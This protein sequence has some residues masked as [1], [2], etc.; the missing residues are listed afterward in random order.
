MVLLGGA[1]HPAWAQAVAP[2]SA[3]DVA[4]YDLPAAS[5]AQT[6]AAITR[7]SGLSIIV[8]QGVSTDTRVPAV[9]GRL[10]GR[11]AL[12]QA[13]TGTGLSIDQQG[14][15]LRVSL[16]QAVSIV[17]KRDKAE[18]SFKADRSDT[19]TR[20][21]TYLMDVPMAVTIVTSKVLESQQ[22][23]STLEALRNVSG[24]GLALT[25][26][27]R[28]EFSVRGF[29]ET[30]QTTNGI[31]D[32]SAAQADVGTVERIEVLK[33]PQ[34]ILAGGDSLGGGVNVVTKRPTVDTVRELTLQFGSGADR[35]VSG[36]V[37]G[38]LSEDKRWSYRLIGSSVRSGETEAGFA[39][40]HNDSLMPSL[41]F[42]D[43]STDLTFSASFSEGR[44]P[45]PDYTFASASGKILSP[46]D[47]LLGTRQDGVDNRQLR[48]GYELEQS[49]SSGWTMVSRMH[50][51][52]DRL[53]LHLWSPF[54]QM[55]DEAGALYGLF[56]ATNDTT[57]SRQL[58]GD[59]YARL[60]FGTGPVRH[61]LSVGFGHENYRAVQ[62]QYE[63]DVQQLALYPAAAAQLPDP[64]ASKL[65]PFQSNIAQQQ[66]A[67]YAQ[68]LMSF[69]DWSLLVN[70]RR[71]RYEQAQ[72]F[73]FDSSTTTLSPSTVYATTPGAGLVY[74]WSESTSLY[75]SYSEG[76]VPQSTPLC[77]GGLAP[78]IESKNKEIGAKFE[79]AQGR[80][81]LTS[82]LYEIQQINSPVVVLPDNCV[83]VK[84][85][86][87]TQGFEIDLQGELIAGW[88]VLGNYTFGKASDA[89]DSK[90][91]ITATPRH[92]LSLW[93]T[94]QL[95]FA[96]LPGL[97][98]GLGVTATSRMAGNTDQAEPFDIP[99]QV[100]LDA[101]LA[102][103][104]PKWS[105]NFG[106][107]NVADRR[108]YGASVSNVYVPVLQSR[109]FMLTL[110]RRFD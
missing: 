50:Q 110:Q 41:R 18:S 47:L 31:A 98:L 7:A 64:R 68:D 67:I 8:D 12:S 16:V 94:Y 27:G 85:S 96:K 63:G 25:P 69:E 48:V 23:T 91:R 10:S 11:E 32:R 73:T 97:S 17:A 105:L 84:P 57:D 80:L 81:S 20:S 29:T 70:L 3:T 82:A 30:S 88:S 26:Q 22:A 42:K 54:A 37:A 100:Q 56:A 83:E 104:Q 87:K 99:G 106:I 36:D 13:L 35:S 72:S 65:N 15:S 2:A 59:H 28:P 103:A 1:V 52:R 74:R 86:R 92:K 89:M 43:A 38:A 9:R 34:A 95:G 93:S 79:F 19:A 14:T 109:S 66:R 61:K 53:Q 44:V 101:S 75:A 60:Q 107:K 21:G 71:T 6:I 24:V 45:V 55:P 78:P 5:L 62:V 4:E 76:F 40:R 90:A 39:G 58:S 49:I 33:G 46:P 102:Y 77:S 108:L 51:V